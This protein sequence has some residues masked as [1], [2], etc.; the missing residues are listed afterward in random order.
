MYHDTGA[1]RRE[2]LAR[3]GDDLAQWLRTRPAEQW[4]MFAAGL[5]LG[6]ILG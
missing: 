4:L 5:A 6:L 1:E 3:L 2:G